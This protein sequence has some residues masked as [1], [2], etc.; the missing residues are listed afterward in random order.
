MCG[1][2]PGPYD[3]EGFKGSY[4]YPGITDLLKGLRGAGYKIYLASM[5]AQS[6]VDSI[7]PY[8]GIRDL[9]EE[10]FGSDP[11]GPIRYKHEFIADLLK[12]KALNPDETA[13]IGDTRH[14]IEAG[15]HNGIFTIG[16]L[17]GFGSEDELRKAGADMI[18]PTVRNLAEFFGLG[19]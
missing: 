5:K 2:F 17:Y 6:G 16:I 1:C 10:A 9:F 4:L 15:K 13:I 19:E 11:W 8:L 18:C 7:V 14:D 3:S 12:R